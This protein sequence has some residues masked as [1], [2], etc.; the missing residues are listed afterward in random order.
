MWV[1]TDKHPKVLTESGMALKIS[2][3]FNVLL[4]IVC[5][6]LSVGKTDDRVDVA[7]EQVCFASA[8]L[9]GDVVMLGDE[10]M[11]CC[12][13]Q[14][15]WPD[16]RIA[17]LSEE[18]AT[19]ADVRQ[20]IKTLGDV[21]PSKMVLMLGYSDLDCGRPVNDVYE[22]FT[23]LADTIVAL[24]PQTEMLFVSQLPVGQNLRYGSGK[25]SVENLLA[26]NLLMKVYLIEKGFTYIDLYESFKSGDGCLRSDYDNGDGFH[27]TPSAYMVMGYRLRGL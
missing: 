11:R 15:L 13:W 10:R 18:N 4:F 22:D 25:V 2:L 8:F 14:A 16:A 3:C 19:I 6:V 26:Y 17:N 9:D 20:K 1:G 7:D 5:L 12:N 27:L 23:A 24:F 21:Q